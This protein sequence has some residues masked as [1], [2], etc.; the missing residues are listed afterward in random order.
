MQQDV[1]LLNWRFRDSHA[2]SWLSGS[3]TDVPAEPPSHRSCLP[4]Q[5]T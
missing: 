2:P 1:Y 5:L 4:F 3:R